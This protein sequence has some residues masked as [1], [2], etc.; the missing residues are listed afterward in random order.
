MRNSPLRSKRH[1]WGLK[2][3]QVPYLGAKMNKRTFPK[4]SSQE[5]EIVCK[6]NHECYPGC[7]DQHIRRTCGRNPPAKDAH[8]NIHRVWC[9]L[10]ADECS[11]QRGIQLRV[12]PR[13]DEEPQTCSNK[14]WCDIFFDFFHHNWVNGK[15]SGLD[16]NRKSKFLISKITSKHGVWFGGGS[17]S[18]VKIK[19]S[20]LRPFSETYL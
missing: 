5:E 18:T 17:A 13:R 8:G 12:P 4:Y 7:K 3:L 16:V 6:L 19:I 15:L 10:S 1:R 20:Y 11:R 14:N 2:H 9:S